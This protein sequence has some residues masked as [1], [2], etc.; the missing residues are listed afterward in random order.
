LGE[1]GAVMQSAWTLDLIDL[2]R[3]LIKVNKPESAISKTI[4]VLDLLDAKLHHNTL[5]VTCKECVWMIDVDSGVRRRVSG[6][7][8]S[9]LDQLSDLASVANVELPEFLKKK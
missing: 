7:V 8:L 5:L 6:K 3:Q 1:E 2:K 9:G 4:F